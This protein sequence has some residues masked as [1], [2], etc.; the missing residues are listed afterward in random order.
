MPLVELWGEISAHD[1]VK[2][3]RVHQKFTNRVD[4]VGRP[5]AAN[6]EVRHLDEGQLVEGGVGHRQPQCGGV[7]ARRA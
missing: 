1:Q 3:V 7:H 5:L 4:R 2:R 6:L